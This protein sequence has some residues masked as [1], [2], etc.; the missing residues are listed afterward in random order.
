M[1]NKLLQYKKH[2]SIT[3]KNIYD[4]K[5]AGDIL[6]ALNERIVK[7]SYRK[8]D[9]SVAVRRG[10][11]KPSLIPSYW[12]RKRAGYKSTRKTICY[13]DFYRNDWRSFRVDHFLSELK[14]VKIYFNDEK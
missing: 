3:S 4:G 9:G 11:R 12:T 2:I 14:N 13:W 5:F 7:F 8:L 6:S 1:N 10:T